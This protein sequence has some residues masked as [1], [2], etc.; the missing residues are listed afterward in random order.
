MTPHSLDGTHE[1][2][3]DEI[4]REV[5]ANREAYA[6]QFD[7]DVRAILRRARERAAEGDPGVTERNPRRVTAPGSG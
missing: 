4:I 7:Y 6:A 2:H 3:Q 1:A 5:R